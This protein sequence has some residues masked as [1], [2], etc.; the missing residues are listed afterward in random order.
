MEPGICVFIPWVTGH[1]RGCLL[2]RGE[3]DAWYVWW[4]G[5]SDGGSD[6]DLFPGARPEID[7]SIPTEPLVR[8]VDIVLMHL[9]M[10]R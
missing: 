6:S 4:D 3:H 9:L 10:S 8:L 2:G 7:R 1:A 5:G